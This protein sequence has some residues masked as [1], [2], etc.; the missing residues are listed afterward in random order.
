MAAPGSA[1]AIE[2]KNAL[3]INHRHVL[4]GSPANFPWTR[5]P[6]TPR[7]PDEEGSVSIHEGAPKPLVANSVGETGIITLSKCLQPTVLLGTCSLPGSPDYELS[8]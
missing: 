6:S 2:C 3:L 1:V 8:W 7:I 5:L 4:I